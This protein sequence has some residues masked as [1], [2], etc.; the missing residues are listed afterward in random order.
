MKTGLKDGRL[1]TASM[2][3]N[4]GR[5]SSAT[6]AGHAC[7]SFTDASFFSCFIIGSEA[8]TRWLHGSPR[9]YLNSLSLSALG[10]VLAI[11]LAGQALVT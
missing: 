7:H 6:T 10:G 5:I 8:L 11:L 9:D 4:T 3:R 1:K 2:G